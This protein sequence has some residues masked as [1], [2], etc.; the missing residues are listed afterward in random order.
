MTGENSVT[1]S[2]PKMYK[3]ILGSLFTISISI[4]N[5][6]PTEAACASTV[7]SYTMKDNVLEEVTTEKDLG[8]DLDSELKFRKQ[9]AAA[10]AKGNQMFVLIKRSFLSIHTDTLP[11]LYKTLVRPHLEYCNLMWGPFNRADEKKTSGTGSENGNEARSSLQVS[12]TYSMM[13]A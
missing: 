7:F 10:V 11:M 13:S 5:V 2:L 3:P 9:A 12:R 6:L 4:W 1:G 8:I